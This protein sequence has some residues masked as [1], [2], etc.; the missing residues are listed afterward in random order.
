MTTHPDGQQ[1]KQQQWPW[2]AGGIALAAVAALLLLMS[3]DATSSNTGNSG[4]GASSAD[5]YDA[6]DVC[7]QA[8]EDRLVSPGSADFS[9]P[10]VNELAG[11]GTA[12][13]VVGD[14]D[15]E[16]RMGASVRITYECKARHVGGTEWEIIDLQHSER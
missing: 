6:R 3:P 15:A 14:V 8:V 2:I 4:A 1:S 16:N 11:S 10:D 13:R 5:E 9:R 7:R 12:Y